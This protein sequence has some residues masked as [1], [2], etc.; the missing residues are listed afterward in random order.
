MKKGYQSRYKAV[1]AV[2][3]MGGLLFLML[4]FSADTAAGV[5]K[6]LTYACDLLVPSLFPFMVLSSFLMRSGFGRYLEGC[7]GFVIRHWYRLPDCAGGAIIFS[8]I[9]GYPVGVSCVRVLWEQ[10]KITDRQAEQMMLFCVGAGPAFLITGI[11]T[12]LLN[13]PQAGVLLFLSQLFSGLLLGRLAGRWLGEPQ[14]KG[15]RQQADV[16]SV[17]MTEAFMVSCSGAAKS[18]LNM[19]AFIAFFSMVLALC[20]RTGLC[21]A[22]KNVL[23]ACGL[24]YPIANNVFHIVMEVTIACQ[25]IGQGGCPLWLM[26]LATGFGGLCVHGQI[27]TM[28]GKM[29][30]NK[31]R[32]LLFRAMNGLL[33]AGIVYTADRFFPQTASVFAVSGAVQAKWFSMSAIGSVALLLLSILFVVSFSFRSATWGRGKLKTQSLFQN[34]LTF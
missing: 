30:M 31:K 2:L 23:M 1:T 19:T 34:S 7:F 11:G 33:S 25:G 20:E 6:G 29:P 24:S 28:A 12:I 9:G 8:F 16:P 15:N 17:S 22:V 18:L 14:P 32:Y 10:K 3:L 4:F 27:L 26:A 21:S 5:K 13:S